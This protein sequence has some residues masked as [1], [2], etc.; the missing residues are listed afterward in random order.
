MLKNPQGPTWG[1]KDFQTPPWVFTAWVLYVHPEGPQQVQPR[2]QTLCQP[3]R[4]GEERNHIHEAKNRWV[5]ATWE[6]AGSFTGHQQ[7]KPRT[8]KGR[9]VSS[10][11]SKPLLLRGPGTESPPVF[12]AWLRKSLTCDQKCSL[13]TSETSWVHLELPCQQ[14]KVSSIATLKGGMTQWHSF[15]WVHSNTCSPR[16]KGASHERGASVTWAGDGL[17]DR[18]RGRC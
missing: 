10:T 8:R 7:T 9:D 15:P 5:T 6:E 16:W 14:S 13:L 17:V 2:L 3:P 4:L 18:R 1:K 12:G 11:T